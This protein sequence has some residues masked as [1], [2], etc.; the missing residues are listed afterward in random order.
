MAA[1]A[2]QAGF[3]FASQT[4]WPL[5]VESKGHPSYHSTVV[6][7]PPAARDRGKLDQ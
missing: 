1:R 6:G 2:S 3:K 4:E 5:S 7:G